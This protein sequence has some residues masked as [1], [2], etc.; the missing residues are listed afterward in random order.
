MK[1]T[2]D[3]LPAL[4]NSGLTQPLCSLEI[5][6]EWNCRQCP[7]AACCEGPCPAP[8]HHWAVFCTLTKPFHAPPSGS[9]EGG[10]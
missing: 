1:G 10:L 5:E 7:A 9:D 3:T 4:G 6:V 2:G 8:F